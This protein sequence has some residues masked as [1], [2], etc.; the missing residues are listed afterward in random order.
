MLFTKA[1]E[2][3]F[4]I[5][6]CQLLITG[7]NAIFTCTIIGEPTPEVRWLIDGQELPESERVTISYENGVS[8]LQINQVTP[9]DQAVY[10][11]EAI[12]KVGKA[13]VSANLVT[14]GNVFLA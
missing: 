3:R 11:V 12:N 2:E 10:V 5:L 6:C 4:I 7:A 1:W 14:L 13:T 9:Q 8:T